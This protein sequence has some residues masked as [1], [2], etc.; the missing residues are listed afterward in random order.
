MILINRHFDSKC[1]VTGWVTTNIVCITIPFMCQVVSDVLEA[2]IG[3]VQCIRK[4]FTPL[5]FF[6]FLLRYSLIL[7]CIKLF[8]FLFNLH[9]ISH[10]DKVK[11][12]F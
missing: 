11:R 12:G 8:V 3:H 7:K 2:R 10:H 9:T 5:D 1:D 4:V 6:H